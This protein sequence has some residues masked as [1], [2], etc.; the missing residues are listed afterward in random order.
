M[1]RLLFVQ[2]WIHDFA[3][4]DLWAKPLGLL[5]IAAYL[6]RAG[7][8]VILIDCLDRFAPRLVKYLRGKYPER[9]YPRATPYGDG[10][11]HA[12]IIPKPP[13]YRDI[14]RRYKRYGMPVELFR[15]LLRESPRPDVVLVTSGLTYWYPGVFEAIRLLREEFGPVPLL[16]GGIYAALCP[17][18]VR[19]NSD[20]DV[21][22]TGAALP[23]ILRLVREVTGTRLPEL[24]P[25]AAEEAR[26]FP[27]YDL[28][29]E[30]RYLTLRTSAGCPFRCSYCGWY[31]LTEGGRYS[32]L[33]PDL[34]GRAIEHSY[35]N[36]NVR[37]FAF[38][39]EALLY[40]AEEHLLPVLKD[41]LRKGLQ[42]FFHTPNALHARFI[43]TETAIAMKRAGF[44]QPRL[45][46]ETVDPERQRQTGGKVNTREVERAFFHLKQA[47]Y[48][49]PEIGINV[50]V[51]LPE[52]PLAE[53]EASLEFVHRLEARIFL[54]EYAPVPGTPAYRESGLPPDADPLL[55]NNSIFPLY[56]PE[57]YAQFQRIKE[58]A[59]RLNRELKGKPGMPD[60]PCHLF[61]TKGR[62]LE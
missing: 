6:R 3:A 54:E 52:Q 27:A 42:C 37:N 51:G 13:A 45:A 5:Q 36:L 46:L 8:E 30:L 48:T 20:A 58:L 23:E 53:V 35:L 2:P 26:V 44:V 14:P 22:Y 31:L 29:P 39:D 50:L 15:R 33:A 57:R 21:V 11:Y 10:S 34:V 4:Y 56:G 12:E 59:H 32:R 49:P 9:R 25:A 47:G 62:Y 19:Q 60:K 28:Y 43:T 38:Y 24:S 41:V 17:E 16:L 55:H 18:H 40:R 7:V 1:K 61:P